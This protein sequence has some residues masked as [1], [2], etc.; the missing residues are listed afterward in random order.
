MPLFLDG[1]WT[2]ISS[3]PGAFLS[4]IALFLVPTKPFRN[5]S[6]FACSTGCSSAAKSM[7]WVGAELCRN[8]PKRHSIIEQQFGMIPNAF[9]GLV[10]L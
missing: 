8:W 10:A 6:V 1:N 4:S 5:G 7:N 3:V 9:T 2:E